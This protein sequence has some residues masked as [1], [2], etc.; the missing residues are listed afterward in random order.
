MT[1]DLG[2]RPEGRTFDEKLGE[3]IHQVIWRRKIKQTEFAK[4]IL[5]ITQ[6]ALSRKL[7]GER[8]FSAEEL[9]Q[10]ADELRLDLNELTPRNFTGPFGP[11]GDGGSSGQ[12][13]AAGKSS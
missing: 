8:P 6:P 4:S 7:R 9:G 1:A 11:D 2:T 13:P 3:A 5:G 12:A 10:I